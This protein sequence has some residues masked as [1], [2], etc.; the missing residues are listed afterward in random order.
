MLYFKALFEGLDAL[1]EADAAVRAAIDARAAREGW[2]ALHAELARV[3]SDDRGAPR[4]QRRAAHPARARG[5]SR[6]R[7]GRFP[8]C[9]SPK[10]AA[11]RA[12]ADLARAER[13]R[14]AA[15]A[16]RR[17]L[18]RRCCAAGLVDEVRRLRARGDL[19][20]GAAVDALR[21][22]P[23]G[24]GR[25]STAAS[26]QRCA[27]TGTAATRQLAKR[28]LTWL[29]GDAG[30]PQRRL[31]RRRRARRRSFAS[32]SARLPPRGR[33]TRMALLEIARSPSATATTA[34]FAQRRPRSW[35]GRVRRHPRRVGR[36]Q[37]DAA[38]LHRRP[39]HAS[40]PARCAS[41]APTSHAL[42]EPAQ[43]AV[44]A[45][46]TSASCSRPST[47]CRTSAV[48][49]NVGLPLLLQLRRPTTARVA[50]DA[51]PRSASPASR[52]RAAADA[53][54]GGQLQ[55]VAIARAL[56]HRPQLILADE[57][58]GNLDPAHRRPGA[59]T[60][61]PTRCASTAPRACSRRTRA[62][63]RRAPTA[64]VTLTPDGIAGADDDG[65]G[66]A[67]ALPSLLRRAVAGP[68]CATIPWRTPW[69]R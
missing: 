3:D 67:F 12:A 10:A 7:A 29:R 36:R 55:R 20:A 41:T 11:E 65:P 6:Q 45:R 43:A 23:P 9:A 31:R 18:R 49:H 39:R 63:L 61:S 34:V 19:H 50:G 8:P 24:V 5:A 40:T 35:R 59:W 58:T 4:R 51:A 57:P 68:S 14:L 2:P 21:R 47:C 17:A 32:P 54:P 28:Q 66:R 22:L 42:A 60:C 30:A 16:H 56:V 1:P 48:A 15:R 62:R 27:Q 53:R 44:P 46:R 52:T 33:L 38:Q 64:C 26:S 13:P 37:V 69:R 25:R